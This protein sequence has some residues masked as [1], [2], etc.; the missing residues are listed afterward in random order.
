MNPPDVSL[1]LDQIDV[2]SVAQVSETKV[3]FTPPLELAGGNHDVN[4]TVGNEAVS[5]KFIEAGA[6]QPLVLAVP[7]T[8]P[9]RSNRAPTPKRRQRSWEPGPHP[10]QSPP[11]ILHQ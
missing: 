7:T 1:M 11:L 4:L 9:E 3:A 2:T 6:A 8:R 5:W 10:P